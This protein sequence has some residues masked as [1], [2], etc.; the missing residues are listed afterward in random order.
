MSEVHLARREQPHAVVR[1]LRESEMPLLRDHLLRLDPAS[2]R[3]RFNGVVDDDFVAKYAAGCSN[4]GVIVIG[5]IE[6]GELHAAA[7]LHEPTQSPIST[8]EIAFSVEQH[9][10]RKGVGSLLFRALLTEA[11]RKGYERLLVTTGAQNGA[12]R[13]LAAKFGTKLN[14]RHGELSGS[15]DLRQV[16]L[17]RKEVL[18]LTINGDLVQAMIGFNQAFWSPLFRMWRY[19]PPKAGKRL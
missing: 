4:E 13:A 6:D 3:D 2:R 5:Y 8:P 16:K 9:L 19:P 10:R 7:E 17:P 1:V 18:P 11:R 14:F 15:L 12:M